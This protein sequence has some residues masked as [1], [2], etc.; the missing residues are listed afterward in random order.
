[1]STSSPSAF[2]EA[3]ANSFNSSSIERL[4][5]HYPAAVVYIRRP[6][7]AVT[8]FEFRQALAAFLARGP[9]IAIKLRHYLRGKNTALLIH[10]WSVS[11]TTLARRTSTVNGTATDVVGLDRVG[12][13]RLLIDNP[14]GSPPKS[15]RPEPRKSAKD[16]KMANATGQLGMVIL[17]VKDMDKACSFYEKTMGLR[18]KFRDG[19]RWAAF[20]AGGTTLALAGGA[21]RLA[22]PISINFKVPDVDIA[23]RQIVNGGGY[24]E[25]DVVAGD[26]ETRA[27]IRDLDG[28]LICLHSPLTK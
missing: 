19:D 22:D 4:T 11:V 12:L 17:N 20:D 18:L 7:A 28:H 8:G 13:W 26:H 9:T 27:A 14:R 21:E 16:L 5:S 23:L 24:L 6:G 2:L 1:L 3:F 15:R 10:D 25:T